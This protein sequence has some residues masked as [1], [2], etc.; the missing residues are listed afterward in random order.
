MDRDRPGQKRRHLIDGYK[1]VRDFIKSVWDPKRKKANSRSLKNLV[2]TKR[3]MARFKRRSSKRFTK[4]LSKRTTTKRSFKRRSTKRRSPKRRFTRKPKKITTVSILKKIC[5]STIFTTHGAYSCASLINLQNS[6][7][8]TYLK[9]QTGSDGMSLEEVFAV[10]SS[11]SSNKA[12]RL[13]IEWVSMKL[14]ISSATTGKSFVTV[15]NYVSKDNMVSN[16]EE[17][18]PLITWAQSLTDVNSLKLTT[19]PYEIPEKSGGRFNKYWRLQD[20]RKF[21]LRAGDTKSI[22]FRRKINRYVTRSEWDQATDKFALKGITSNILI[23]TMGQTAV[24]ALD[25]TLIGIAPSKILL[26]YNYSIS[27]KLPLENAIRV[28]E[29]ANTVDP[30]GLTG[31]AKA[32]NQDADVTMTVENL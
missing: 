3:N 5:P 21:E 13:F 15:R 12:S 11:T 7:G 25:N 17:A 6:T 18:N 19:T 9:G 30:L 14:Q 10:D 22:T 2:N 24:A 23:T 1:E 32:I 27:T 29:L 4:R 16:A 20:I 28:Q 8:K 31:N 26:N